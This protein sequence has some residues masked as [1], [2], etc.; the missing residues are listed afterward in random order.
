MSDNRWRPAPF[1]G[2]TDIDRHELDLALKTIYD[3][4]YTLADSIVF[5]TLT[6]RG[7]VMKAVATGLSTLSNVIVSIDAGAAPTNLTVTAS[8]S[9]TPGAF[10]VYVW[11]PTSAVDNTPVPAVSPVTVRWSAKGS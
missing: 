11:R 5:G 9:R 2:L 6:V 4:H 7:G 8:L 1:E 10:D 3:A